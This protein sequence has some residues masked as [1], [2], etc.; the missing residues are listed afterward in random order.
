M[1]VGSSFP[2]LSFLFGRSRTMKTRDIAFLLSL[3]LHLPHCRKR[4]RRSLSEN[5]P[6]LNCIMNFFATCH[7]SKIY[8]LKKQPSNLLMMEK[9]NANKCHRYTIL[10]TS[11]NDIIIT[12]TTTG[13]SDK[14][15]TTLVSTFYVITKGEESIRAQ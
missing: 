13:L 2:N 6:T 7:L 15:Y 14:L 4:T 1:A 9:T 12:N 11:L 5:Y 8:K 10:I 3:C